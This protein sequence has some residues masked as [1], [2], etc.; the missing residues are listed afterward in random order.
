MKHSLIALVFLLAV[1][2]NIAIV[3]GATYVVPHSPQH[4]PSDTLGADR[5]VSFFDLPL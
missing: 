1:I 3:Q 2:S 5:I 4:G